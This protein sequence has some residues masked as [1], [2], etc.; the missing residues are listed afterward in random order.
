MR[1]IEFRGKKEIITNENIGYC[2]NGW[3]YGDSIYQEGKDVYILPNGISS[4]AYHVE[5]YNFRANSDRFEIMVAKIKPETLGQYTGL[6]DKN[7][8]KI[9]E[10]DIVK[11]K[12]IN[13]NT[14]ITAT[15]IFYN[16]GFCLYGS[17]SIELCYPALKICDM[18]SYEV[19]G[20]IY[21]NPE[22][23]NGE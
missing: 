17:D 2:P 1:E 15:I 10:G 6:K 8:T 3:V 4:E 5:P 22:L 19:I 14:E 20:N 23:V 9:F 13:D 7:G 12:F 18:W 21:D 11:W 16:G